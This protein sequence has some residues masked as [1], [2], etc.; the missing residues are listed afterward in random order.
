MENDGCK[1][2]LRPE[3]KEKGAAEEVE[4]SWNR[5]PGQAVQALS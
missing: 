1:L 4:N 3:Y 2:K 5:L